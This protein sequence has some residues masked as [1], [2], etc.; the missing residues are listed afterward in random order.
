[1]EAPIWFT[2]LVMPG[3]M[4]GLVLAERI[5]EQWPELPVLLT[6]GY[7]EELVAQGPH[8]SPV[9]VLNKPYRRADLAERVR[10]VLG[11]RKNSP[12]QRALKFRHEG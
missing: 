9:T 12:L 10:A 7:M 11:A 8:S 3:G 4:N 2:D 6:T 1:M 5:R